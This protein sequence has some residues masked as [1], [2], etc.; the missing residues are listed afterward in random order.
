MRERD[1]ERAGAERDAAI[2]AAAD[3]GVA[4]LEF[5]RAEQGLRERWPAEVTP[6]TVFWTLASEAALQALAE[7][8]VR[9][10]SMIHL[11]QAH[12]LAR[13]RGPEWTPAA[14]GFMQEHHV[15]GIRAARLTIVADSCAR[16]ASRP[17]RL[18][19]RPTHCFACRFRTRTA[20]SAPVRASGNTESSRPEDR[21][22]CALS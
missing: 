15:R 3:L 7:G 17:R 6:H 11:W 12:W 18:R 14:R 8:N 19:P 4:G 22:R 2:A 9:A 1:D 13:R 10:V 20:S 16:F 5:A 21:S